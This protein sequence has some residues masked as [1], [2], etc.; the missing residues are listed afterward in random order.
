MIHIF[1]DYYITANE[2]LSK[3]EILKGYRVVDSAYTFIEA[4]YKLR[5]LAFLREIANEE[6]ELNTALLIYSDID[7]K[8]SK[9]RRFN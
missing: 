7:M 9:A 6:Y 1:E 4:V 5:E 8:I 3:Y 2:S